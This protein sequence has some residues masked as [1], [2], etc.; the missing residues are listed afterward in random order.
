[1]QA[2]FCHIAMGLVFCAAIALSESRFAAAEPACTSDDE[3]VCKA[4]KDARIAMY[5]KGRNAYENARMTG[6]YTEAFTVSH[7]L[8]LTGDKNGE[9]L[10]KMVFIQLGRGEHKDLVQAYGWLSDGVADGLDYVSLWRNK[11]VEKMSQE[12]L[13]E[14]KKKAGN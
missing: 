8:A 14:A 2:K 7:K 4:E 5:I 11:L 13:V 3:A 12:Q 10:L 6:D 1:M 9:R